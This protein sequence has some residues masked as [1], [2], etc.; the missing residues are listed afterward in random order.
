[1]VTRL[2]PWFLDR[3]A[4]NFSL[5][6]NSIFGW[7]AVGR[8]LKNNS[9]LETNA[10]KLCNIKPDHNVLEI[11]F[12]PGVG[13]EAAYNIVK[14][15]SGKVHG[16]DTSL[17]MVETST[18]RLQKA[19][20]DEKV[21]LFHGSA[22]NIPLNTDSVHRVFHCNCYYFWPNVRTVLR[23]IYRVM[24]PGSIMVTTLNLEKLKLAQNIGI[25]KYG[26]PD[27]V[28]YMS[29]LEKYGFENVRMEYKK[30]EDT[31]KEFQVI[32]AEVTEKPAHDKP[33]L[34]DDEDDALEREELRRMIQAE[35]EAQYRDEKK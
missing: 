20:G 7:L 12:G 24:I 13:L 14:G 17:Y 18:K 3:L 30:D 29:S 8:M 5:P 6:E 21:Q 4:R 33:M 19:I 23:E 28:K 27:P 35:K 9:F 25:L 34:S 10:V 31:G 2:K 22:S 26:R 16:I 1:M 11:G 32:F 15:G